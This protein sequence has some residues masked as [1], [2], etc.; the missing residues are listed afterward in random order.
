[1]HIDDIKNF[2]D[3]QQLDIRQT[4]S[5]RFTDQKVKIDNLQ[6]ISDCVLQLNK[7]EFTVKNV[8]NLEYAKDKIKIFYDKPSVAPNEYDKLYGQPLKALAY[9]GILL[10]KKIGGANSYSIVNKELLE[11]IAKDH[12]R[13]LQFTNIYFEKVLRQ[14]G[15]WKRVSDYM[16]AIAG[17]DD[18]VKLKNEFHVYMK[19]HTKIGSKGSGKPTEVN[20]IFNPM[21]NIL[22]FCRKLSGTRGGRVSEIDIND[23]LY[24][25][26]NWR[27]KKKL[28]NETR[29]EYE[30]RV[31]SSNKVE[32]LEENKY[33]SYLEDK[34]KKLIKNLYGDKSEM[35]GESN[36]TEVHH[37]FP[38]S[39]FPQFSYFTENMILLTPNQHRNDAHKNNFQ[40]VCEKYQVECLKKK[41][42]SI[43][44]ALAAMNDAYDIFRFSGMLT[45]GYSESD[46]V[47]P[48]FAEINQFL[49]EKLRLLYGS[50]YLNK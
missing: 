3:K 46:N 4:N 22:C 10:E 20:R 23:L 14:S 35:N 37:I 6:F 39:K 24:N 49:D 48:N 11:F 15:L 8:R 47:K 50:N 5:I 13:A 34:N 18:L 29:K 17:N 44:N 32:K 1:M 21:L 38:K 30:Q 43:N 26:V 9:S 41:N 33:F 31:L 27:D 7:A 45:E 36:A 16:R 25:R 42:K 2:L 12:F 28:K 40:S 19:L